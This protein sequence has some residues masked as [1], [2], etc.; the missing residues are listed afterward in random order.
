[1]SSVSRKITKLANSLSQKNPLI[2][3]DNSRGFLHGEKSSR[4]NLELYDFLDPLVFVN[5]KQ[6]EMK[7]KF[8]ACVRQKI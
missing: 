5:E 4:S 3:Y 2:L 6:L 8:S 1:M 7:P